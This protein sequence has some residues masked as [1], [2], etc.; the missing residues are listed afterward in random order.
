[1]WLTCIYL[2]SLFTPNIVNNKCIP[3]FTNCKHDLFYYGSDIRKNYKL[4]RGLKELVQD[5]HCIPRQ[6]RN[7]K[8]IRQIGFD[9]N[10]SRNIIMMPNKRGK[11]ELNLHPDILVHD[12]G[13]TAYNKYIGKELERIY[14]EEETIDMK[15]YK[16]WLFLSFL[17]ESL[18]FNREKLPWQ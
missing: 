9:I 8:L 15:K 5:H 13:H 3:L 16:F 6:F 4:H 17:K 10:C 1:M 18:P 12:G 7:H 14:R 2:L 11:K